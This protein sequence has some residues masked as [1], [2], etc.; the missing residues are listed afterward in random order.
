MTTIP[1][2]QIPPAGIV[3]PVNVRR[4]IGVD[5]SLTATGIADDDGASVVK[6]KHKGMERLHEISEAVIV[7]ALYPFPPALVVIE[8]YSMGAQRGSAGVAQMLG[9]LGGVVRYRLHELGV[10]WLD[11][12]P[13]SL[14]LFATGKGNAGKPDMLDA[15]RRCG[16]EGSN[17]NNAV[18]AWF[19]RQFGLYLHGE[20]TVPTTA[21]RDKA[22][23]AYRVAVA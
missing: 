11:V 15:S 2:T 10:K 12:P 4:C 17:D 6:S 23:A 18:D 19:L 1:A 21:Y 3:A 5:L 13:A 20:A 8:G 16:Y 7:A 22:T 14:K 9:E